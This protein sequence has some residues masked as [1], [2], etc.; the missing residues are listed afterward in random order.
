MFFEPIASLAW[1]TTDLDGFS[2]S[3]ASVA[4][5]DADSLLGKAGARLG[6]T[7]GSGNV[8]WTPYIGVYAVEEFEGSNGLSFTSGPTTISFEDTERDGYGQVDFGFTAQTFYGLEG[9]VK[10]HWN[11]GSDA[12]GGGARVGARWRW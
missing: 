6:G 2:S 4:F 8:V 7:F 9:F 3:G 11:F 10:G 1:T 5:D 12:D